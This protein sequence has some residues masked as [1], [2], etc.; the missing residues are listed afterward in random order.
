MDFSPCS[1]WK[2]ERTFIWSLL[3]EP[4]QAPRGKSHNTV[5]YPLWPFLP[6]VFNSQTCPHWIS[7]NSSITVQVSFSGTGFCRG[8]S[9]FCWWVS[10]LLWWSVPAYLSPQFGGKGQRFTLWPHFSDRSKKSCWLFNIIHSEYEATLDLHMQFEFCRQAYMLDCFQFPGGAV[11]KNPPAMQ[12]MQE[13]QV[14]SL[15]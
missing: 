10:A 4:G 1:C 7:I 2:L 15:G 6:G 3:W 14:W 5:E 12:E 8:T 9:G 13:I 11:V